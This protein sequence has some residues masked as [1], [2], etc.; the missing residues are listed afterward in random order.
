MI[1]DARD[2]ADRRRWRTSIGSR[3]GKRAPISLAASTEERIGFRHFPGALADDRARAYL[4]DSQFDEWKLP[5][6][7]TELNAHVEPELARSPAPSLLRSPARS[8]APSE[9]WRRASSAGGPR[10]LRVAL[11]RSWIKFGGRERERESTP[12][13]PAGEFIRLE[14]I[15]RVCTSGVT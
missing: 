15:G 12:P 6:S 11:S 4:S 7:K 9:V 3:Q 5:L 14:L 2:R 10:T 1:D 13:V 8:L